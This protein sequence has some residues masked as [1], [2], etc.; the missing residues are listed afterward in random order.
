MDYENQSLLKNFM[1]NSSFHG[2]KY[3]AEPGRHWSE[4]LF[5]VLSCSTSW[6]ISITLMYSTWIS[7]QNNAISFMV[8]TSYTE[9]DSKFPAVFVCD[10]KNDD[11]IATVSDKIYGDPHDYT[12]DE[13]VK[14]LAFYDENYFFTMEICGPHKRNPHPMCY[15]TNI[16]DIA[17][18]VQSTCSE[19]FLGCAW[20]K[21]PFECCKHF[22]PITT[23]LGVCYGLNS[24]QTNHALKLQMISNRTLGPGSLQ[25][26]LNGRKQVYILGPLEVPSTVTSKRDFI[27]VVPSSKTK[28]TFNLKDIE[29]EPEVKSLN[30]HQ[31]KCRFAE[32]NYLDV[33]N[34]YSYS[35]CLMQCR[36]DAQLRKCGCA[37]HLMPN[38]TYEK[39]CNFS[40]LACLQQNLR[41]L[42]VQKP[43]GS[44]KIGL[45]CSCL[46]SCMEIQLDVVTEETFDVPEE[47]GMLELALEKLPTERFK[48][49]VVKGHLDVVVSIGSASTL[50]VGASFL[51]FVEIIYYLIFLPFNNYIKRLLKARSTTLMAWF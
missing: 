13:M 42:T 51:S 20:N 50:F 32:E 35:A 46:P 40:G 7:Y 30:I 21:N 25:L 37:H 16:S 11:K 26:E 14:E 49:N 38:L 31:R 19:T 27:Q 9:W 15:L 33:I 34:S 1:L 2:L 17:N 24:I 4:R 23:D 29:N 5:W 3:L 28:R 22:A 8:E 43:P 12:L 36:K 41:E 39:H 18:Q 48:R 6:Y 10:V 45:E 47:F 44:T